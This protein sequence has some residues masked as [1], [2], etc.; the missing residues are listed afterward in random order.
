MSPW[1]LIF[2]SLG[3]DPICLSL[4]FT[5]LQLWPLG[6]LPGWLLCPLDR[7]L[8][9]C[10]LSTSLVSDSMRL[11]RFILSFPCPSAEVSHGS[12]EHEFLCWRMVFNNQYPELAVFI[13]T[14][15]RVVTCKA[16]KARKCYMFTNPHVDTYLCL[17]LYPSIY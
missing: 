5:W 8:S 1:L 9:F 11:S 2:F 7:C 4:L 6:A 16:G 17:F 15:I 14:L 12:A 3:N 13:A 10:A